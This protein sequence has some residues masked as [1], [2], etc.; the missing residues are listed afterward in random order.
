LRVNAESRARPEGVP[1]WDCFST[2]NLLPHAKGDLSDLELRNLAFIRSIVLLQKCDDII[3]S[4]RK[5]SR[6]VGWPHRPSPLEQRQFALI[7]F[8]ASHND[9]S[10]KVVTVETMTA[11]RKRSSE[12]Q[13]ICFTRA[14][15][16][17]K[18]LIQRR[19]LPGKR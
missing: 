12:Q 15:F 7:V 1:Q 13:Q 9:R 11:G 8:P 16:S 19:D 4:G 10:Q 17:K 2:L 18:A 5:S 6:S 14:I 3:K